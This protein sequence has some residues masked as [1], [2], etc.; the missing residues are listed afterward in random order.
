MKH[1]KHDVALRALPLDQRGFTLLEAII[2]LAV[3]AFGVLTVC[4]MQ[5]GALR[6]STTAFNRSE[7]NGI[8]TA[9]VECFQA[10]PYDD[11][12][13]TITGAGAS[14]AL[15]ATATSG[16]QGDYKYYGKD[17]D[18]PAKLTK[19]MKELITPINNEGAVLGGS[20][21]RY[22]LKWAVQEERD[23]VGGEEKSI[24]KNI[25]VFLNWKSPMGENHLEFTTT[26]Y[27]N[28]TQ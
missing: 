18:N 25:R 12:K 22:I 14:N 10:L 20:G 13:V 24:R 26:K 1:E 21:M 4:M 15:P 3:L 16:A 27:P 7:A 28:M 6:S 17:K 11:I 8:A 23:E 5:T 19:M 2:A 9:L